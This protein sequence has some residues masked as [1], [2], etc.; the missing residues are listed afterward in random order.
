VKV[1]TRSA[2]EAAVLEWGNSAIIS[3]LDAAVASFGPQTSLGA[4]FEVETQ[5]VLAQPIN[6]LGNKILS[7]E[8]VPYPGPLDNAED[9]N[10]NMV[11]MT[12]QPSPSGNS[13]T[14]VQM[15]RIAAESNAA[16]LL[17]VNLDESTPDFI[18]RVGPESPQEEAYAAEYVDFPV[19]MIS[20]ASGNLLTSA[21]VEEGMD[22]DEVENNGMPDRVRLYAADDRPFFE[23]VS[24]NEPIL[25]L[26]HNLLTVEECKALVDFAE[27]SH[28]LRT[29]EDSKSRLLEHTVA[30]PPGKSRATNIQR[31]KQWK[32]AVNSQPGKLIEERIEQ[33]TGYPQ[34]QF[35]DW[36]LT[37]FEEGSQMD[38]DMDSHPLYPPVA[39]ITVFLNTVDTDSGGNMVFPYLGGTNPD[40]VLIHPTQ[41]LAVVHH[42]I[43]FEGQIEPHSIYGDLPLVKGVIY[44]ARKFVYAEPLPPSQRV[45]LPLLAWVFGGALPR[46]VE[47]LH[48]RLL[49]NYGLQQGIVHF[50]KIMVIGPFILVGLLVS[51]IG[52]LVVG[53]K[54][55]SVSTKGSSSKKRKKQ[56]KKEN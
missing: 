54:E 32:G 50:D 9:V 13:L 49:V 7:E 44:V 27:T 31:T 46:W 53:T 14:P 25:Y 4:F 10:G 43:D 1:P 55:K 11:V 21:T 42:T 6:G 20:L 33:V 47:E 15:A 45:V 38:L 22:L 28:S 18:Y 52:K 40:P 8:D 2:H 26:I 30:P 37:K 3:A 24:S 12:N 35:S 51:V 16:A 48:D 34:A 23:D 36:Q 17:I 29:V 5:P 56:K 39:T 19:V 41:G